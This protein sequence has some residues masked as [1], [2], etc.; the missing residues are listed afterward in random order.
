MGSLLNIGKNLR[1]YQRRFVQFASE[2]SSALLMYSK[3]LQKRSLSSG[4]LV[5]TVELTSR[6]R[7]PKM[8]SLGG[9][10]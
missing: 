1:V 9:R 8:S 3:L 4:Q 7:Q 6:K 10:L 5:I 2:D